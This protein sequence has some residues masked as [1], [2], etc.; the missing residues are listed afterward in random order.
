MNMRFENYHLK[1]KAMQWNFLF[2]DKKETIEK[3]YFSPRV[4]SR[5][6]P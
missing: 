2:S 4:K 1:S 5:N 6:N 3:K